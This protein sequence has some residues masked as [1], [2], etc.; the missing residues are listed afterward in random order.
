MVS[1]SKET[2]SP[3]LKALTLMLCAAGV[4][5]SLDPEACLKPSFL[6]AS[7]MKPKPWPPFTI[8]NYGNHH[9]G[10]SH[11]HYRYHL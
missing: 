11:C 6:L 4:S 1:L 5:P 2:P 3:N 9:N 7:S 8:N 10:S